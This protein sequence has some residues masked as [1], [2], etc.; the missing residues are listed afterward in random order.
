MGSVASSHATKVRA[1]VSMG[2]RVVSSGGAAAKSNRAVGS[3]SR[4]EEH[5][6]VAG[7]NREGTG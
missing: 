7:E 1:R 4:W 5:D 3:K 6:A 2:G